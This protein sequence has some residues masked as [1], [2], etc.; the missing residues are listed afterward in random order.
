MIILD[1]LD[2]NQY[3]DV[4]EINKNSSL[5]VHILDNTG[6]IDI[7]RPSSSSRQHAYFMEYDII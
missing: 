6:F 3:I 1:F 7:E 2:D 4:D 5:K